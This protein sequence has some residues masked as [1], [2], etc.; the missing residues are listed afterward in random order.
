[1]NPAV[2]LRTKIQVTM[3]QRRRG[4]A[5]PRAVPTTAICPMH[6]LIGL[7]KLWVLQTQ[8]GDLPRYGFPLS[9]K[10]YRADRPYRLPISIGLHGDP[11]Q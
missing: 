3:D 5:Q 8:R 4:A 10:L 9:L 1:V 6:P 2:A 11:S 7:T